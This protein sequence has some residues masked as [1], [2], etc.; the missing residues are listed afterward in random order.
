MVHRDAV[1]LQHQLEITVDREE[2]VP[3]RPRGSPRW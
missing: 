1:I 2:Q 3:A